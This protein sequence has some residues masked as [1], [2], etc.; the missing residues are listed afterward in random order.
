MIV[1]GILLVAIAASC[2]N[3]LSGAG[4]FAPVERVHRAG[5]ASPETATVDGVIS[6][7]KL[8]PSG[9][10]VH[11]FYLDDGTEVNLPPHAHEAYVG[12]VGQRVEVTGRIHTNLTGES[13]V[14]ATSITN[15][16]TG[17]TLDIENFVPPAK[18]K[19]GK[20]KA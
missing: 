6:R 15:D 20:G 13:L 19:H 18:G 8:S 7:V 3:E 1:A 12:E 5:T 2:A 17:T 9:R 4:G 14:N 16:N 10:R 11:G